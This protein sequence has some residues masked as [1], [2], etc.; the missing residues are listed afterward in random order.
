[1]FKHNLKIAFR[2]LRKYKTQ[3]IISIIGLAV[4]FV[5]FA[6][7]AL[8]IRYEMTFDGFHKNA[9]QMYVVYRPDIRSQT[10][11]SRLTPASMAA[12][13]TETFPEIENAATFTYTKNSFIVEDVEV[14]VTIIGGDSSLLKMFDV[15]IV[16][17]S[18]EF[19]VRGSNTLAVTDEKARQLFGNENPIGKTVSNIYNNRF[20]ICAVVSGMSGRSNFDFDFIGRS[21]SNPQYTVIE[22]FPGI[23]IEAFKK[24]LYEHETGEVLGNI[25]KMTI[26]PLP[27]MRYLDPDIV[28]EVKFQ[29]ILI[30]AISGL[31]VIVCALF[32]Y[33]TL[34]MSRF[35]IRQKELALRMVCGASGRSLLAMLSIEILL[36]LLFAVILGNMLTQLAHNTFLTMSDIQMDL[37][38]IYRE[39]LLYFGGIILVS[40]FVFWAILVVFRMRT[41]NVSISR[42]NKKTFRKISVVVQLVISIG[43]A[44]CTIVILKQMY[45]LHNSGELGFSYSN[46]GSMIVMDRFGTEALVN[47]LR[48]IPEIME[49]VEIVYSDGGMFNLIPERFIPDL[50]ILSWD[51][52]P[53]EAEDIQMWEYR[54]S[55]EIID[56]YDFQLLSGEMLTD[57]DPQSMVLLNESAVKAFGWHDPVGKYFENYTV[58]GVIKNV[59]NTA[60]TMPAKPAFYTKY[61]PPPPPPPTETVID[62]ETVLFRI[63]LNRSIMFKY[64]EGM[65]ESCREKIIRLVED[66]YP[67]IS[68]YLELYNTEEEYDKFLKSENALMKL[69]SVVSG[70][71]ILIC[72]FGFVS[73]VSLTCEERRKE[74]AIRKINGATAGDILAMFAKEYFLLLFV[75]A[76]IAF[77]AGYFIM[78]R[79]LENYAIRTNIPAWIYLAIIGVLALVIALCVGWRVYRASVE[80]PAEVVKSG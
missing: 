58:K 28:R 8:W 59:Y 32:N 57:A 37:S 9:G 13:L 48:Q 31:L 51:D 15:K 11:Y 71:C 70:I 35:R 76:V 14:P 42:S 68:R 16:E 44:F 55:P 72:V 21:W 40:L 67:N 74:I 6:F 66:E 50:Q 7:S 60:P 41:L 29:Y 52:K 79:W 17:G 54:V 10:G 1:M 2:N 36:T 33:L 20:E 18:M 22:L 39:S 43:I 77:T 64:H 49:V 38:A 80:N 69:L 78:Q 75:G 30:F 63:I 24:K 73:L 53:V 62:S 45:F 25:S 19:L 56:F 12:H 23:N 47:Q 5:C 61:I 46:R 3:N 27:K 34:F 26:M 65:W 4:G